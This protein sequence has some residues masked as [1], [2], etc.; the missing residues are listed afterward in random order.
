MNDYK[1]T[2]IFQILIKGC[3]ANGILESWIDKNLETDLRFRRAKTRGHVVIE[4]KDVLFANYIRRW[5]PGC[6]INIKG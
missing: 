6:Q 1:G 5:Y 4:T 3:E 2:E